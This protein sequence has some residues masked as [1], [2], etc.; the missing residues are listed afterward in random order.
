[1]DNRPKIKPSNGIG[2]TLPMKP[3]RLAAGFMMLLD[4]LL[5]ERANK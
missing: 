1:M 3:R 5:W 2:E 4:S